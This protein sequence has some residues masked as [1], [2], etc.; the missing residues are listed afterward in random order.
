M[1]KKVD[2][3]LT[4][5]TI[6]DWGKALLLLLDEAVIVVLAIVALRFFGIGIPLPVAIVIALVLGGFVFVIHVAVIP[7]FHIRAVTGSEGMIGTEGRVVEPL[8]PVGTV[9]VKGEYW[10]A[11]SVDDNI[12]ADATVEILGL[13]GLT[14]KVRQNPAGPQNTAKTNWQ[15]QD[16][17]L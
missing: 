17:N 14:L 2:I 15:R 8:N 7:S 10:R 5:R 4:K 16:L 11:R 9:F 3:K 13:D 6:K 1:R 12:A